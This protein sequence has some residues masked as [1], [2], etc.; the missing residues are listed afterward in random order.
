[1]GK[2]WINAP[3]VPVRTAF[4]PV[5]RSAGA[6]WTIEGTMQKATMW[7]MPIA[8]IVA[9]DWGSFVDLPK[10]AVSTGR[11]GRIWPTFLFFWGSIGN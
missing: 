8:P 9:K 10:Q 11:L 2:P 4:H 7:N 3:Y 5:I 6:G 1:M